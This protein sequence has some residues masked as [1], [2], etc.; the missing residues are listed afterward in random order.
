MRGRPAREL[1]RQSAP[2]IAVAAVLVVAPAAA[3]GARHPDQPPSA[4]ATLAPDPVPG[5][6]QAADAK[7]T[8]T[9]PSSRHVYVAPVS[10][11]SV[12]PAKVIQRPK[13]AS[14]RRTN[15]PTPAPA[16]PSRYLLPRIA[17]PALV[18]TGPVHAPRDLDAI[19]AGFALLL[20]AVTAGSGAR[21][22]SIWNRRAGAA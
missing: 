1:L 17:L 16:H 5:T 20:A 6:A 3:A 4:A 22:V 13:P 19:L 15:R 14:V 12:V 18:A 10:A 7:R 8:T 2:L 11:R 21:L 9:P